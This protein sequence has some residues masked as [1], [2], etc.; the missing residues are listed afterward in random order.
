MCQC[1]CTRHWKH[2]GTFLKVGGRVSRGDGIMVGHGKKG[3]RFIYMAGT[4]FSD[5]E[6]EK[7]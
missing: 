1:R 6:E 2:S 3:M 5:Y 4:D 7:M